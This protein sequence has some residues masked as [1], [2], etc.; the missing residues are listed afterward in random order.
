M[1]PDQTSRGQIRASQG[2]PGPITVGSNRATAGPAARCPYLSF[3]RA[4]LPLLYAEPRVSSRVLRPS[5]WSGFAADRGALSH[6]GRRRTMRDVR[7]NTLIPACQA[8]AAQPPSHPS[9]AS[10]SPGSG[11]LSP[12]QA[13]AT[14]PCL[15]PSCRSPSTDT[16]Q[17]GTPPS[18]CPLR[19]PI[20][21]PPPR[22]T[23]RQPTPSGQIFAG[24]TPPPPILRSSVSSS[25]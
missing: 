1:E 18:A 20:S 15:L 21:P 16:R 17:Q 10:G 6:A 11:Q 4:G 19:P 3:L 5:L 14:L 25:P 13:P 23:R 8:P 22:Q 2:Q 12:A 7:A 9:A 24:S